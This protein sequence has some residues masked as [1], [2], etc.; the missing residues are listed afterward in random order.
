M[1]NGCVA[2]LEG[3]DLLSKERKSRATLKAQL[4]LVGQNRSSFLQ[5]KTISGFLSRDGADNLVLGRVIWRP[6]F[7]TIAP[8]DPVV[9]LGNRGVCVL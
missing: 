9:N 3:R 6:A 2:S 7:N 4:S 8:N 5:L 1:P